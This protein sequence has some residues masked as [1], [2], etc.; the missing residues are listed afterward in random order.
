MHGG[1]TTDINGYLT[2]KDVPSVPAYFHAD[3]SKVVTLAPWLRF[4]LRRVTFRK[5]TQKSFQDETVMIK[6]WY[7]RVVVQQQLTIQK[8]QHLTVKVTY[9]IVEVVAYSDVYYWHGCLNY[10]S[11]ISLAVKGFI[12]GLSLVV[13]EYFFRLLFAWFSDSF[14]FV[15]DVVIQQVRFKLLTLGSIASSRNGC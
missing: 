12:Q 9:T 1:E 8:E 13:G 10:Q 5:P 11:K 6:I 7:Y 4:L 15:T 3:L 2:W 14:C